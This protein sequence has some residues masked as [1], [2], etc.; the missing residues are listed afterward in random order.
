MLNHIFNLIFPKICIH[1]RTNI[2]SKESLLC[3][4]CRS[5]L[6][7]RSGDFCPQCGAI[8]NS[9]KCEMCEEINYCFDKAFSAFS[10]TK[11]MKS[12]IYSIKYDDMKK[13]GEFLAFYLSEYWEKYVN[14]LDIDY[15]IPVPLHKVKKRMRGYNQASII[16]EN[17]AKLLNFKFDSS[18]I[19]RI[20]FTK[21]QT[22]L[23]KFQR[24]KNIKNAFKITKADKIK[25]KN[26]L[27]ID[28]VFT[29]GSTVNE[30]SEMLKNNNA[31][32]IYILTV[33]R[34]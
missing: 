2:T 15:V 28:D 1:C 7:F 8:L 31:G 14:I 4:V 9:N 22:K 34:A 23:T 29:T 11:V 10:Y 30:I 19:K 5:T 3:D 17:F 25:D 26:I 27:V 12:L 32:K 21:T 6:E 20:Y 33:S 18:L 13:V 24:A 16:G